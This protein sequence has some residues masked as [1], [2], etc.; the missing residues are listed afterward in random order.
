MSPATWLVGVVVPVDNRVG[1]VPHDAAQL[2]RRHESGAL[3]GEAVWPETGHV[4][5]NGLVEQACLHAQ[6]GAV[7]CGPPAWEVQ[8]L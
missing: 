3:I 6:P 4:V 8:T 7:S 1:V 5:E 2:R